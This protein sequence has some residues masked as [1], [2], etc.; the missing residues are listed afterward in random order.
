MVKPAL[1]VVIPAYN[2]EAVIR[3]TTEEVARYLTESAITYELLI[4][5]DGSTDHTVALVRE[6]MQRHPSLR[7]LQANHEGKGAAVKAG[8]LAAAG[9]R[10]LFMDADHST[11]I[12]EWKKCIPWLHDGYDVVIGSRKM[13]G[14]DVKVH[15]PLLRELMGKVFTRLTNTLLTTQVTDITC[16]FKCFQADVAV[17]IFRLQRI[18][19]WGFDAELLFLARRM[20]YRIKE[21]PV[22]WMD[23]ASTKV[24]L[25]SDAIRSF[26]ELMRIR[27]G[28]WRGWYPLHVQSQVRE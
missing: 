15:Q 2:E 8:V 22:V 9:S 5:D 28:A 1:S 20:G 21:V 25:M 26:N 16:G 12:Q 6:L 13:P 3:Q 11:H 17:R 18:A 10:I 4:V 14:A 19:G 24:R 27:I 23:D 7:L